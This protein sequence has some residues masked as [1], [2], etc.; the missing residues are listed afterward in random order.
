[1]TFYFF[2]V[3]YSKLLNIVVVSTYSTFLLSELGL[4]IVNVNLSYENF[5]MILSIK[6]MKYSSVYFKLSLVFSFKSF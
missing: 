6:R 3:Y 4:V 2:S 1:M 5:E